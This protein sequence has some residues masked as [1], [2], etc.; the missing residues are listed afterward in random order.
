M[1]L[2]PKMLMGVG[3]FSTLFFA[4]GPLI[5]ATRFLKTGISRLVVLEFMGWDFAGFVSFTL[6]LAVLVAALL[7][8]ERLSRDSE[9]GGAVRGRH[10]VPADDAS[11]AGAGA[12][13]ER[14]R[15]LLQ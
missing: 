8:F 13:G 15:L 2:V 1:D 10:L 14:G 6:P 4:L 12:G 9:G 3:L 11:R 5:A 7:G